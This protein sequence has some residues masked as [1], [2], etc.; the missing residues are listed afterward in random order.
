M[1]QAP[2]EKGRVVQIHCFTVVAFIALAAG[3]LA[4]VATCP[5]PLRGHYDHLLW[6]MPALAIGAYY[7]FIRFHPTIAALFN[8]LGLVG[9]GI[10]G[11]MLASVVTVHTGRQFPLTDQTLAAADRF[12]YFDWLTVLKLFD[13]FPQLDALLKG[14]YQSIHVQIILILVALALTQQL[15]RLYRFLMATNMAL[16]ITCVVAVFLP[17]LGPYELLN[18]TAADHPNISV[19]TGAKMTEPILWIRA[20]VFGDPGPTIEIGLISFPSFHAATA[21]IYMW[22][23]WR[24]PIIRWISLALNT[25]M[26]IATPIHG[27]HYLVDHGQHE[28]VARRVSTVVDMRS[29][30]RG[31]LWIG[32]LSGHH[33][34]TGRMAG[35]QHR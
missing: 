3:R 31:A 21:A 13:R 19:I 33:A 26:L 1:T 8:G 7:T 12:I 22:A 17:A 6:T 2:P 32:R 35:S 27:S 11:G 29:V 10:I 16:L 25:L 14:A 15:E 30:N 9:I 23:T 24:T 18:L 28:R 5:I 4:Y 34:P 20:G